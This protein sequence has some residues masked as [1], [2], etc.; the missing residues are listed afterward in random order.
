MKV[1]FCFIAFVL[2]ISSL[3]MSIMKKDDQIFH[4]FN[5]LLDNHQK[6]KYQSIIFERSLI[7]GIGMLLGLGIG[8]SYFMNNRK[9][10]YLFCKV[11]AIIYIVKLGFYYL[12]PKSPLMLYSLTTKQQT[13]AW[14]DIYSE[15]KNRWKISLFAGFIGYLFLGF[16]LTRK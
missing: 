6:K 12:F 14:A 1:S 7:Y 9:E 13:D 5:N 2:L 15:M 3:Y 8:L 4:S 16:A 11:I 10:P